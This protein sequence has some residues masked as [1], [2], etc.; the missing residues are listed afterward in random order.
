MNKQLLKKSY[1]AALFS[2]LMIVIGPLVSQ[3]IA[4]DELEVI[5]T[6]SGIKIVSLSDANDAGRSGSALNSCDYCKLSVKAIESL[7][8][9]ASNLPF[10]NTNNIFSTKER[11]LRYIRLAL[12]AYD[13]QAPPIFL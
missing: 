2:I 6:S 12:L 8:Y 11:F 7:N 3:A 10:L 9:K 13:R 5:C 4:A 1:W